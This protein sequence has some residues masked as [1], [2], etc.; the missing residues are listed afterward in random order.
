MSETSSMARGAVVTGGA[1]ARRGRP[2][3]PRSEAG[4]ALAREGV[5]R[6]EG[7]FSGGHAPE[8]AGGPAPHRTWQERGRRSEAGSTR[9]PGRRLGCSKCGAGRWGRADRAGPRLRRT[10]LCRVSGVT[11][12][13]C[14]GNGV[15]LLRPRVPACVRMEQ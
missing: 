8:A 15:M 2:G 10:V 4:G 14:P 6:L 9:M 12:S 3:R 13:V 1:A 7:R 5:W 11:R